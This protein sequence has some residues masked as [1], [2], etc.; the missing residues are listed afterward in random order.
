MLT[1]CHSFMF[2]LFTISKFVFKW[3]RCWSFLLLYGCVLCWTLK[4]RH[5]RYHIHSMY[6]GANKPYSK[7]LSGLSWWW[8]FWCWVGKTYHVDRFCTE[9]KTVYKFYGCP[10]WFDWKNDHFQTDIRM[11]SETMQWEQLQDTFDIITNLEPHKAFYE[12]R[13][14]GLKLFWE[15]KENNIIEY[16]DFT[17]LY[18]FINKAKIYHIGYPV[19][20]CEN[21]QEVPNYFG[22]IKCKVLAPSNL[23]HPVIPFV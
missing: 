20:I 9:K 15:T 11:Y 18:P 3:N 21:F 8:D 7:T 2:M 19:I 23:Y 12:G 17:L 22:V 4:K 10:L 1:K 14:K 16:V 5:D 13:V 6:H